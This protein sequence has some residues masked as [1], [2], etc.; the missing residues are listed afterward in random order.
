MRGLDPRIHD[1]IQHS[2]TSRMDHRIEQRRAA[3]YTRGTLPSGDDE[4]KR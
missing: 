3:R 4:G 1:E 2:L